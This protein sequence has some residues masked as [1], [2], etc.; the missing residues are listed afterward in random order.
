[1]NFLNFGQRKLFE[2]LV[3]S[4]TFRSFVYK[5][6][7]FLLKSLRF[8]TNPEKSNAEF[9]REQLEMTEKLSEEIKKRLSDKPQNMD[10]ILNK[11]INFENVIPTPIL[12]KYRE[13]RYNY[14]VWKN[15]KK[16]F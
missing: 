9:S 12:N 15:T 2:Y 11:Q 3:K 16:W 1:M 8:L 6:E 10:N 4:P 13:L 7:G 14:N 5:T